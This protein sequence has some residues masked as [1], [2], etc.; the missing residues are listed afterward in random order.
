M[1]QSQLIDGQELYTPALIRSRLENEG[2]F[3]VRSFT[4]GKLLWVTGIDGGSA[5][6]QYL[7]SKTRWMMRITNLKSL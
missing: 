6:V 4:T 2:C 1:K 5:V 7:G 3:H